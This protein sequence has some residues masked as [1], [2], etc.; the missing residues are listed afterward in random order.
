MPE[1]MNP[2][3]ENDTTVVHV[4]QS[5]YLYRDADNRPVTEES[6]MEEE[7]WFGDSS[8]AAVRCAQLNAHNRVHYDVAMARARRERDAKI[9]AAETANREA[10]ILRA[11]GMQK[12]DVVVPKPFVPIP[13]EAYTPEHGQTVYAV[14]TITR[15]EHDSGGSVP[16]MSRAESDATQDVTSGTA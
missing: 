13:F 10:S 3:D 9:L 12:R 1:S 8:S 2:A 11:N 15:S 14:I 5:T 4:I 6:I 7:G 16:V